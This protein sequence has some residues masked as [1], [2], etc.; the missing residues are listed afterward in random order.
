MELSELS[1]KPELIE[2]TIDD[3]ETIAEYG[4]QLTFYTFDR[5]PLDIFLK[6]ASA[7]QNDPGS[8]ISALRPMLLNKEGKPIIK[9]EE[10]LPTNILVKSIAKLVERLGK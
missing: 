4:E 8:M 6:M 7:K 9:G 5:Q 1:K 2:I 3:E 10:V